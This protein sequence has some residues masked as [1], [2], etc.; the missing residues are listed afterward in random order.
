MT[1]RACPPD[2]RLRGTNFPEQFDVSVGIKTRWGRTTVWQDCPPNNPFKV[3]S[4]RSSQGPRSIGERHASLQQRRDDR[5][6]VFGIVD[7]HTAP[8]AGELEQLVAYDGCVA[9]WLPR[10]VSR[11][12]GCRRAASRSSIAKESS[13][14]CE[15]PPV[16]EQHGCIVAFANIWPGP[17][18]VELSLDLMRHRHDAPNEVIQSLRGYKDQLT[19]QR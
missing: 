17:K 10:V 5:A 7:E 14:R 3:P 19:W 2:N 9:G 18:K 11:R 15:M 4:P 6:R 1:E 16:I 12:L 8:V 13:S